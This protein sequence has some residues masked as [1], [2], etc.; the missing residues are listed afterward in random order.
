MKRG[1]QRTLWNLQ[2]PLS[3]KGKEG[4]SPGYWGGYMPEPQTHDPLIFPSPLYSQGRP[5]DKSDLAIRGV[6]WQSG[7][8]MHH[9]Q[10]W[11]GLGL[12]IN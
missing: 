8:Q 7:P 11:A 5:P 10:S 4:Q 2:P 9:L 6:L 1:L 12:F 3:L